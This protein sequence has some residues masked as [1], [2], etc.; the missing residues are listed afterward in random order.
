MIKNL[1]LLVFVFIS[2]CAK[3]QIKKGTLLV[4][5]Q[6]SAGKNDRS[7]NYSSFPIP[8]PTPYYQN[9]KLKYV[10]V[11]ISIGKAIK[12]NKIIGLNFNLA[13]YK[14]TYFYTPTETS[15]SKNNLNEAGIFYRAYKKIGKDIYFFGQANA[16]ANFGKTQNNFTTSLNNSTIKQVGGTLSFSLGLAYA[17]SK[18]FHIELSMQNLVAIQYFSSK[19]QFKNPAIPTLYNDSYSFNSSLSTGFLGNIGIGFRLVL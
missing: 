8:Q 19:Q 7:I 18:K 17:I 13:N 3:A 2:F 12:D 11:G 6:I 15:V 5:G 1:T 9:D 10:N 4:G 14:Q 16:L